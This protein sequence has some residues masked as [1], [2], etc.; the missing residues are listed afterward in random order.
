MSDFEQTLKERESI[1]DR[2]KLFEEIEKLKA[3]IEM[4]KNCGNCK[5]RDNCDGE[6]CKGFISD[7]A[8]WE[9]EG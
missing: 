1:D 4:M 9:M 6:D 7:Y 5:H 3:Q 8:H 2:I